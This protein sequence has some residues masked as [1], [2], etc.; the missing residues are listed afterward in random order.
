MYGLKN[1][2]CGRFCWYAP[3]ARGVVVLAIRSA[4]RLRLGGQRTMALLPTWNPAH[5]QTRNHS[6]AGLTVVPS[7]WSLAT[8]AP[9]CSTPSRRCSAPAVPF[10]HRQRL[11]RAV[12]IFW[13]LT[14][15]V[16]AQIRGAGAARRQ[17]RRGR[18]GGHAGAGLAR[19]EG[20]S[21]ALRRWMLLVG[22]FGT[23]LF[24]GDGVITPAITVLGGGGLEVMSPA[25]MAP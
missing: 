23:C 7:A 20:S 10:T 18:P 8:S 21:P 12:L 14:I 13:T 6:L 2:A 3:V 19:G 15:I 17:Q 1:A 22:I 4:L 9:A 5:V 11:R 24:Y 25:F 16:S